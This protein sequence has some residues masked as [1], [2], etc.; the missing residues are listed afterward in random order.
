VLFY[1]LL[2]HPEVLKKLVAEIDAAFESQ[3]AE[4]EIL[5]EEYLTSPR[6]KLLEACLNETLRLY[7]VVPV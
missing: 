7:P 1:H 2:T 5:A 3:G 6:L 4:S